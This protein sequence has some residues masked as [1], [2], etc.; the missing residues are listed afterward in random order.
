MR[1]RLNGLLKASRTLGAMKSF[2]VWITF[3]FAELFDIKF[4][5]FEHVNAVKI[6]NSRPLPDHEENRKWKNYHYEKGAGDNFKSCAIFIVKNVDFCANDIK[7]KKRY[8][9][10]LFSRN[11]TF[12]TLKVSQK[13]NSSLGSAL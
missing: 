6:L 11:F 8:N 5:N 4:E 9:N 2:I 1:I 10:I 13:S 7:F 3:Y 12:W